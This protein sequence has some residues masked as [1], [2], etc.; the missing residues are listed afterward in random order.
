MGGVS[1]VQGEL[2]G[3]EQQDEESGDG[4]G[5]RLHPADVDSMAHPDLVQGRVG[6]AEFK[7]LSGL[8]SV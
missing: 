7:H 3:P 4:R 2:E 8:T 5:H 1:P 6:R